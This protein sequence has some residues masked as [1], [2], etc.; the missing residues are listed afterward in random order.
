MRTVRSTITSAIAALAAATHPVAAAPNEAALTIPYTLASDAKVSLLL[1]AADGSVVCELLHAA[2]RKAGPNQEP[3]DGLDERGVPVPAGKYPWKLLATQGLKAEYLMAVGTNATPSWEPWPGNHGPACFVAADADGLYLA[4]GCGEGTALVIKQSPAGTRQWTIPHWLEAWVGP[5]AMASDG[6]QL[7]MLQI[8]SKIHRADAAT[9]TPN[10]VWDVGF[11][12]DRKASVFTDVSNIIDLD[13]GAG[14]VV[15]SYQRQNLIR[16]LDPKNGNE[17]DHATLPRP[18]GVAVDRADGSVLVISGGQVLRLSRAAKTPKVVI[19]RDKLNGPRKLSVSPK[20]REIL[21]AENRNVCLWVEEQY[22]SA[23]PLNPESQAARNKYYARQK[24][25]GGDPAGGKQVKRFSAAGQLLAAYGAPA[26][27]TYVPYHPEDF[28]GLVDIAATADGGFVIG[29]EDVVRRSALFDA[30]GRFVREWFGG[31]NYGQYSVP[32]PADPTILWLP[33]GLTLLKTKVDLPNKGWKLLASYDLSPLGDWFGLGSQYWRVLRRQG[34][35]YMACMGRYACMG[36]VVMR[37]DEKSNKLVLASVTNVNIGQDRENILVRATRPVLAEALRDKPS[38]SCYS[39]NDLDGNGEPSVAEFKVIPWYTHGMGF[40]IDD[41]FT[42]YFHGQDDALKEVGLFK[43]AVKSW[44]AQGVPVYDLTDRQIVMKTPFATDSVWKDRDGGIFSFTNTTGLNDRKFGMGFWSPRA[45]ANRVSKHAADGKPLWTVGRHAP[46][47]V[48]EPGE[49][50]YLY[51]ITGTAHGCVVINDVEDSL[52]HVWDADGLWVGRLLESPRLGPDS[53]KGAYEL[54]GENFGG[55]L[56]TDPKT[57]D[58]LFYGG[59]IN[60]VPIYRITGWDDFKRQRG[61]V[62]VSQKLA[63]S[64]EARIKV[65]AAREDMARISYLESN[66]VKIDGDL[67]EWEKVQPLLIKDGAKILAKVFVVWT[68]DGLV[69][70][71]DVNT[72]SPWASA[73]SEQLPFQGGA[74]VD[75]NIGPMEPDRKSPGDGDQR[76]VVAPI[77]GKTTAVEILPV[78]AK[79]MSPPHHRRE[80]TYKTQIGSITYDRAA[81]IDGHAAAKPKPD[82]KGYLVEMRIPYHSPFAFKPGLRFRFDASVILA[83]PNGTRSVA[84]VPWHSRN[85][86]DMAVQDTYTEGL[87]RPMNWAEAILE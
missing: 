43:L 36:P 29:E 83:N 3:W 76:M 38:A 71:F 33:T 9:G 86:D 77:G 39:W 64:L 24:T 57:G 5:G 48:P 16:W 84:R 55:S 59:G 18:G 15:V 45:S 42:W 32:D 37:L 10:A 85:A 28:S 27:R 31:H 67:A 66:K 21:V 46:G 81:V 40:Y 69:A 68:P 60:N 25:P 72:D 26:G 73:G 79:G 49:A 1:T 80:V 65:E 14:Q 82:G 34:A 53:P 75:I 20:S 47:S 63:Q 54:C 52:M 7:F 41:D 17:I 4:T 30:N 62:E 2:P 87:L 19:T 56:H 35:T 13:A 11:A 78:L 44:T 74:A 23:Q 70:A 51:T 6:G 50:K 22:F 12:D 61:Q 8:N 58:V